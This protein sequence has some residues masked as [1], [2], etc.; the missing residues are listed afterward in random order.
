[1]SACRRLLPLLDAFVDGELSSDQTL[2]VEQHLVDCR[3]CQAHIALQRALKISLRRAVRESETASDAFR[4]RVVSALSA[5]RDREQAQITPLPRTRMLAW[6][7]IIPLV[8][9]TA[10]AAVSNTDGRQQH[11]FDGGSA[12]G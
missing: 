2:E 4:R 11:R 12:V 10:A 9:A 7:T 8:A 5:E 3:T 1:M 6:R